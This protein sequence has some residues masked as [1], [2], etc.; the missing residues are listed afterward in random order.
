MQWPAGAAPSSGM[1]LKTLGGLSVEGSTFTRPVPLLLLAYVRLRGGD[2]R[3]KL[4]STFFIDRTD[5]GDSLSV[6]LRQLERGLG[7]GVVD[8][9]SDPVKCQIPC[10][11]D[12]L[13]DAHALSDF[14]R[15]CSLYTGPFL[16]D[17]ES[18]RY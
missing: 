11:L 4:A 6:A 12:E 3:Q 16:A 8:R 2:S 7:A 9:D 17:I 18:S 15:V 13:N 10:D 5:P 1:R 14:E